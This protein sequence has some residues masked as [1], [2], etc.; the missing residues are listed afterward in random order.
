LPVTILLLKI[1][2]HVKAFVAGWELIWF[3]W[4]SSGEFFNSASEDNTI[5]SPALRSSVRLGLCSLSCLIRVAS[6]V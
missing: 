6:W 5:L 2:A 1:Y 4:P 3:H